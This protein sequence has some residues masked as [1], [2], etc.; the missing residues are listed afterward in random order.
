[1]SNDERMTNVEARMSKGR[2]QKT[3]V[4]RAGGVSPPW[5]ESDQ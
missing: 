4:R 3:V 1:M 2:G 5:A